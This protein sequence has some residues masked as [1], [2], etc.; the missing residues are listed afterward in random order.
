[1]RRDLSGLIAGLLGAGYLVIALAFLK[2][3]VRTRDRLFVLFSIAFALLFA[4]RVASVIAAQWTDATLWVY[5]MRLAAFVLIL[6]AIVDKNTPR[7]G[8]A[9]LD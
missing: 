5:V 2:F 3:W 6:A 9:P 7:S 1:M 4:E 8:T